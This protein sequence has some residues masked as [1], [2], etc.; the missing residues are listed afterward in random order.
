MS[1]NDEYFNRKGVIKR[2]CGFTLML[3]RAA[4]KKYNLILFKYAQY[5]Y[6]PRKYDCRNQGIV[7]R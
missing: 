3:W 4:Q 6:N 2:S 7:R 1:Q 5:T